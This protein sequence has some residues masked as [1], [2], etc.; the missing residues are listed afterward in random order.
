MNFVFPSWARIAIALLLF[1]AGYWTRGSIEARKEVHEL[2]QQVK[3]D[4]RADETVAEKLRSEAR[5][6][7]QLDTAKHKNQEAA[8]RDPSYRQYLDTEL[9]AQSRSFLRDAESI[10]PSADGAKS[11]L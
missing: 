4:V 1:A 3:Q 11:R 10:D 6:D 9:P 7:A 2:K 5:A 8:K